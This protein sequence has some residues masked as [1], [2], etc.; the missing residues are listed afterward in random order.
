LVGAVE[1]LRAAGQ[2][3]NEAVARVLREA[4]FTT[5]NRLV[6]IRL[7]D[8]RGTGTVPSM[9]RCLSLFSSLQEFFAGAERLWRAS[10]AFI[11]A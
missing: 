2:S 10:R 5:L 1:H 7:A 8:S 6:A 11:V 4:A 3:P 9:E